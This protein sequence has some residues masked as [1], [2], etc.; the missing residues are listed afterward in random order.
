MDLVGKTFLRNLVLV[1]R[2]TGN[3]KLKITASSQIDDIKTDRCSNR[4]LQMT[5][6]YGHISITFIQRCFTT[7]FIALV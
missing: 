6:L 2:G 7:R 3:L 4:Y 5:Y 1:C